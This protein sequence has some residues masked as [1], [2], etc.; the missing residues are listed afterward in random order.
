MSPEIARRVVELFRL[1]RP[2]EQASYGL[3]PQETR[4]LNLLARGHHYKTA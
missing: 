1:F 4:L 3:T 2:V